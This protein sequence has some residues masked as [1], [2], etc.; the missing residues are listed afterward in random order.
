MKVI[1]GKE[2]DGGK[3]GVV[4]IEKKKRREERKKAEKAGNKWSVGLGQGR[5]KEG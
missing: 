4:N 1:E 2:R 3:N 5:W